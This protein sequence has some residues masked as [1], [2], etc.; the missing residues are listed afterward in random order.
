[1][2][3]N[4][5]MKLVFLMCSLRGLKMNFVFKIDHKNVSVVS[6]ISLG[7]DRESD[8]NK[9]P[10]FRALCAS[11][12]SSLGYNPDGDHLPPPQ[13]PDTLSGE[14]LP[15]RFPCASGDR[16]PPP[17]RLFSDPSAPSLKSTT[18]CR[19]LLRGRS[20]FGYSM[21]TVNSVSSPT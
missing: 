6:Y 14:R 19:L 16:P 15:N 4:V 20:Y 10:S 11:A 5:F 8:Y 17:P 9:S 1:M 2:S 12:S 13:Q 21:R 7:N 18:R 3:Q